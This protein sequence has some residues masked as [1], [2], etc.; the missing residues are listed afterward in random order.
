MFA[1]R[2][3]P[4]LAWRRA[5]AAIAVWLLSWAPSACGWAFAQ[6]DVDLDV[7]KVAADRHRANRERIAT[8]E[9]RVAVTTS[10]Q[11]MGA[12]YDGTLR[13]TGRFA[14]D[15]ASGNK[16]WN[17]DGDPLSPPSDLSERNSNGGMLKDNAY[18][19]LHRKDPSHAVT[20]LVGPAED[21]RDVIGGWWNPVLNPEIWIDY[22]GAKLDEFLLMMRRDWEKAKVH[23]ELDY[24]LRRTGSVL[25]LERHMK[26]KTGFNGGQTEEIDLAQGGNLVRFFN[27]S[28][29][30][31]EDWRWKWEEAS[32]VWVPKQI[33][34]VSKRKPNTI[35]SRTFV[36]TENRVNESLPPDAFT[37]EAMGARPG[38]FVLDKRTGTK[39]RIPLPEPVAPPRRAW[40]LWAVGVLLAPALLLVVFLVLRRRRISRAS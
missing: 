16:R 18:Y 3:V 26:P 9:G 7:L 29:D 32:G 31:I 12:P 17:W 5:L 23:P 19:M 20:V 39:Y 22:H 28:G 35:E 1:I 34:I 10:R 33:D 8:W 24:S 15:V 38:D 2:S 6:G 11:G 36:I 27:E 25:F 13:A 4:G 40:P 21:A 30:G 14:W 37:V